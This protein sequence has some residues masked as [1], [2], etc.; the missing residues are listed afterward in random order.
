MDFFDFGVAVLCAR[1]ALPKPSVDTEMLQLEVE[2]NSNADAALVKDRLQALCVDYAATVRA[3][4]ESD[5]VTDPWFWPV[6]VDVSP[7][8]PPGQLLWL[9]R[10]YLVV[11]SEGLE[12]AAA[13]HA[14]LLPNFHDIL[15][16][17][18]FGYLPGADSSVILQPQDHRES[19]SWLVRV[20]AL[21]NAHYAAFMEIDQTLLRQ[22]VVFTVQ[23]RT[24]GAWQL[25]KLAAPILQMY[26][27]VRLLRAKLETTVTHMGS[28]SAGIWDVTARVQRDEHVMSSV[29]DKLDALQQ[30]HASRTAAQASARARR[31]NQTVMVFTAV[32]VVA[33]LAAV[34]DFAFSETLSTPDIIRTLVIL[35]VTL[36][37][38]LVVVMGTQEGRRRS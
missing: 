9:H 18:E 20:L 21:Q 38:A 26:E 34:I 1:F 2:G 3:Q 7:I 14:C 23:T 30:I 8:A 4:L 33:S 19:A 35:V 29:N 16:F 27:G 37:C 5:V 13:R 24:A 36:S 25:E 12:R 28:V 11:T 10:I 32:S 6:D 15:T 22:L 17:D 31:L